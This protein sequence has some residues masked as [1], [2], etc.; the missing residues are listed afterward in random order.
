MSVTTESEANSIA[1]KQS[2][3]KL[4]TTVGLLVQSLKVSKKLN[5]ALGPLG[6]A[7]VKDKTGNGVVNCC[8]QI[9]EDVLH[10]RTKRNWETSRLR[11][12]VP[13][14]AGKMETVGAEP[15]FLLGKS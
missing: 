15:R 4:G 2:K 8:A 13:A 3:V 11:H 10:G 7:R 6:G 5:L 1:R 9:V 12:W 14:G